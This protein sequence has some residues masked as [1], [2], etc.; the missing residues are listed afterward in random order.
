MRD[1]INLSTE[2]LREMMETLRAG[3][4]T[5]RNNRWARRTAF[6]TP[7]QEKPQ[8]IIEQVPEQEI[9]PTVNWLNRPRTRTVGSFTT[10]STKG[11]VKIWNDGGE[12]N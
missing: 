11:P 8:E 3:I 6:I 9:E 1:K 4:E 7:V 5:A 12:I 10:L 2:R